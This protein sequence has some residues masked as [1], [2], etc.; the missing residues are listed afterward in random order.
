MLVRH[1]GRPVTARRWLL[2]ATGGRDSSRGA[3]LVEFSLVFP[4]F[5]LL[6]FGLLDV[7]HMV[8]V[9]NALSEGAR[10]GSRYASVAARSQTSSSRAAVA[11]WT[12]SKLAAVPSVTVT[13][14]CEREGAVVSTC[15]SGDMVVVRAVSNV[16]PL[17]PVI[18]QLV[19]TINVDAESRVAVQQ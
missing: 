5:M 2:R 3:T 16:S 11:T 15:H 9:N 8:Y 1:H 10:E 12:K 13:V 14:T 4:I 17:T 6:V 7:G 18:G 19:G